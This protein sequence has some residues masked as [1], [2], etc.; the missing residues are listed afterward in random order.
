MYLG[1]FDGITIFLKTFVLLI[2]EK[3][4]VCL[5][6]VSG[7]TDYFASTEQEAFRI[8]RAS[9]SAFNITPVQRKTSYEKPVYDSSELLG[10]IPADNNENLDVHKV[11]LF[12]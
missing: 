9:V 6:S 12:L 11:R 8:G 10:I 7:C 1:A 5:F 4:M 2:E 3:F